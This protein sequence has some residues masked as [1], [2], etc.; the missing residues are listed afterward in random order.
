MLCMLVVVSRGP[1]DNRALAGLVLRLNLVLPVQYSVNGQPDS[2]AF[3]SNLQESYSST[4]M[5]CA[6]RYVSNPRTYVLSLQLYL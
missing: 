4:A 2:S 5:P 1:L 3:C 6:I